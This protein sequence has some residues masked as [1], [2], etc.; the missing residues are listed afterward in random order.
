MK[1]LDSALDISKDPEKTEEEQ[2]AAIIHKFKS[3]DFRQTSDAALKSYGAISD[4]D[5]KKIHS[6]YKE[7]ARE[8]N[9]ISNKISEKISSVYEKT[10]KKDDTHLK[11]RLKYA[12]TI[13]LMAIGQS[14]SDT[15]Y[16]KR[17]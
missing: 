1:I 6:M 8:K 5:Y 13:A 16:R 10:E 3:N 4:S 11:E 14:S 2:N 9:E 17:A 7:D 15:F 12:K